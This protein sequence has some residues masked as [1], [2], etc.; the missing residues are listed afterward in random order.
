M[1]EESLS[2]TQ[3]D[4]SQHSILLTQGTM[5][6]A[7]QI[8][9]IHEGTQYLSIYVTTDQN[10]HPMEEH[11]WQKVLLYTNAFQHTAMS[12]HEAGVLYHS[13]FIPVLTYPVLATS[14][15]DQFFEKVH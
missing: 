11:L 9:Q 10:T 15:P 14:L 13:C 3:P 4:L 1:Q 7:I 2:F 12:H 5:H 8:K 6:Q